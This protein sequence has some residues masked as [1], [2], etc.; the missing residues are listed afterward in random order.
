MDSGIA[1]SQL[2][3]SCFLRLPLFFAARDQEK[4]AKSNDQTDESWNSPASPI[5][6]RKDKRVAGK[7]R[8]IEQ[9][10]Y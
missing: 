4:I 10:S 6:C 2:V 7:N 9:A 5:A 1:R 3:S 8:K